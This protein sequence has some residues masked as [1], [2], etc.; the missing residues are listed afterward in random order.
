M[1]AINM[2]VYY[3]PEG[4]PNIRDYFPG[5]DFEKVDEWVV[6]VKDDQDHTIATS[7]INQLGCCCTEDK[8]R[9]HFVN[10]LG[11]MDAINVIRVIEETEVKSDTWEKSQNFPLDKTKGG[12]YRKNITSNESYEAETRC[13]GEKD[14]YWIKDLINSPYAWIETLLPNG[15]QSQ[16]KIEYI[17]IDISDVKLPTK[18]NTSRYE[19]IV[20]IKF[21][22]SNDNKTIR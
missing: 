21:T 17:P 4:I 9:I 12:V 13:Y 14:Q 5:I 7:R 1:A 11:E 22:M 3:I 15:F 19:Y 6:Y 16:Q 2:N 8:V 18:K 10:S 20:K